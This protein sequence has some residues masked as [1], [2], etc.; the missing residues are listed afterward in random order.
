MT[1][2]PIIA[3]QAPRL[4]SLDWARGWLLVITIAVN[5]ALVT[6]PWLKHAVWDTVMPV[7]LV[8][9]AFVTLS[10][11]SIAFALSRRV[12]VGSA[13]R[14]VIV[15]FA[16]GLLYNAMMS[17]S[18]D[19]ATLR[20]TGV[21][22]LY[23]VLVAGMS[24]AHL[25]TRTWRGWALITVGVTVTHSIVLASSAQ[26][27]PTGTLTQ[28][29]N[30]SA[31]IDERVFGAAHLYAQG[32][33]G[34]DPEGLV[35]ILGALVSASAGATLGHLLLALRRRRAGSSAI[36]WADAVPLLLVTAG[37]FGLAIVIL[38]GTP[39]IFGV[40]LPVMKRLW[41]APFALFVA[42]GTAVVLLLG[43]L[44]LDWGGDRRVLRI[45]SYPLEA[46]GRNSLLVYFG[47]HLLT[48]LL[49]Q[50]AADGAPL[51]QRIAEAL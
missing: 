48:S 41:T 36:P 4:V 45:G 5:S 30:P 44:L 49:G 11:C 18:F 17:R 13:A 29:C 34:H 19:W 40:E 16:L 32:A 22:Q 35:S 26:H 7:D 51:D 10:G 38:A 21:L 14:R 20:I 12:Q 31:G 6:P 37:L 33:A 42:S 27:C 8:F 3:T 47:V 9:P 28:E 2:G 24:L 43:H 46:L 25:I 50:P 23:A 15:L 39:V 1:Q